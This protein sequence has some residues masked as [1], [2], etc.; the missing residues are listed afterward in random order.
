[1]SRSAVVRTFV[2][3]D[4]APDVHQAIVELKGELARVPSQVRWVRNEGLHATLKFL[5]AVQADR[6]EQVGEAVARAT[7][8]IAAFMARVRGLGA[9]PSIKRPRV[10]WVGMEA[11]PLTTLAQ[12]VE[13]ELV[14]LGFARD[15]RP[16]HPHVTLGRVSGGRGWK[17]LERL[18]ERHW[19]DDFGATPVNS[20]TVYRSD[21]RPGGPVYTAL[22]TRALADSTR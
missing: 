14:S 9:F 22:W 5:G 10:L 13:R 20:V 7:A 3:V 12:A 15:P 16:F 6:A 11:R 4:L 19:T 18:L 21:L 2:A 17:A 8:S 1:M